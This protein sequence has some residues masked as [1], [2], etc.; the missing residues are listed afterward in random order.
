M[1][2]SGPSSQ[3][4]QIR[5]NQDLLAKFRPGFPATFGGQ[6]KDLRMRAK[7]M[8]GFVSHTVPEVRNDTRII[9]V[10]GVTDIDDQAAPAEDGW[11][12]SD[13]FAFHTLFYGHGS[14]QVWCSSEQPSDLL[15]KY[16][17]YL[18][19]NPYSDRRVVLNERLVI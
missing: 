3:T 14:S 13:F 12:F 7:E 18:H 11:F 8:G 1:S 19:G 4:S 10:C 6:F 2:A 9:A 15:Q 17:Q 5:F 16:G